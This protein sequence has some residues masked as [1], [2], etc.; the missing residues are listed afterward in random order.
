MFFVNNSFW[1]AAGRWP[2]DKVKLVADKKLSNSGETITYTVSYRKTTG[3]A[4]NNVSVSVP[5]PTGTQLVSDSITNAG[6]A[7]TEK[8]SWTAPALPPGQLFT[9]QFKV[10]VNW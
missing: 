10:K 5:I 9:A 4:L 8:I 7:T 6:I 2:S 3:G 1:M